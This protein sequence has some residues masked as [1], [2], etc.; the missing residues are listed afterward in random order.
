MYPLARLGT[1]AIYASGQLPRFAWYAGHFYALSQ[2]A[3]RERK[4]V[5][6]SPRPKLRKDS[7]IEQR[8]NDDMATLFELDLANV[9]AG[10]YPIPADHDGSV[11]TMLERSWQF[12]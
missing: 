4:Q 9:E 10:I 6:R 7:N 12:F 11:L 5:D 1:R 8:L 2:L 3:K